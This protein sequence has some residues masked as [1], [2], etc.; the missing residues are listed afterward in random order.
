MFF[1]DTT[2]Q[3]GPTCSSTT[4]VRAGAESDY[5]NLKE[6]Y[7][8]L[9]NVLLETNTY[10]LSS[11]AEGTLCILSLIDQKK[12]GF[13]KIQKLHKI[14]GSWKRLVELQENVV[15]AG[16]D[17]KAML[18]ILAKLST[19]NFADFVVER[20]FTRNPIFKFKFEEDIYLYL[21]LPDSRANNEKSTALFSLEEG[22]LKVASNYTTIEEIVSG[23]DAY[24]NQ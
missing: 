4:V 12:D 8:R 18:P 2:P 7:E 16:F 15:H 13:N 17:A 14:F 11:D 24:L 19:M 21:S 1:T 5:T 10:R 9:S 3:D 6:L 22:G 23:V 20:S